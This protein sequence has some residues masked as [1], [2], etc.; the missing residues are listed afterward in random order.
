VYGDSPF[1]VQVSR[2]LAE[3]YSE[4]IAINIVEQFYLDQRAHLVSG[5]RVCSL[6]FSHQIGGLYVFGYKEKTLNDISFCI[7]RKT[8]TGN[9]GYPYQQY[10]YMY[11]HY[12]IRE[13]R[14]LP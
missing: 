10:I 3:G 2:T 12:C 1:T 8:S 4:N 13:R 6:K 7:Y 14:Y 11:L 5:T 9:I